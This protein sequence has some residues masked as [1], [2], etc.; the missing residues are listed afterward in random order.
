MLKSQTVLTWGNNVKSRWARD[1]LDAVCGGVLVEAA[2]G[3]CED[4]ENGVGGGT[5]G[6]G[7]R[8][9]MVEL[10]HQVQ[11]T[12]GT[13]YMSSVYIKHQVHVI[14]LMSSVYIKHQVHV[15]H[16]MSSV[17]IKH[18]VHVIHLMSSVYIKHQV[19]VIHLMSSVY[20]KHQVH[21]IHLMSS[22]LY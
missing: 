9:A 5:K 11:W 7:V 1:T 12:V 19:H 17:Y 6:E 16:L 8:P 22:V 14:H 21:V 20:I 13:K 4:T 2:G 15:I 10:V 18:Q 3:S